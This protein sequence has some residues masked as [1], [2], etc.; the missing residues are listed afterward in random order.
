MLSGRAPRASGSAYVVGLAQFPVCNPSFTPSGG[1]QA[2]CGR[3]QLG[4]PCGEPSSPAAQRVRKRRVG[5][6]ERVRTSVSAIRGVH[7]VVVCGLATCWLWSSLSG[8]TCRYRDVAP[9]VHTLA[10]TMVTCVSICMLDRI[11][12]GRSRPVHEQKCTGASAS[13]R[14]ARCSRISDV[15]GGAEAAGDLRAWRQRLLGHRVDR[16]RLGRTGCGAR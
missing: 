6:G 9:G 1:Q 7:A 3:G 2:A 4:A 12:V 14:E 10:L 5:S 15:A 16:D 8:A 11:H 13:T